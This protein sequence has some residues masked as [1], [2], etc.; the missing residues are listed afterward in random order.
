[1]N[2]PLVL[3]F[4]VG[5]QSVRAVLIDRKGTVV[6]LERE[7]YDKPYYSLHPNWAEQSPDY[8]YNQICAACRRLRDQSPT[9]FARIGWVTLTAFRDSTVCLSEKGEPLRDCILWMD[10]RTAEHPKPLPAGHRALF[11]AVGMSETIGMLQRTGACN[12]FSENEPELWE[13]TDEYVGLST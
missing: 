6:A 4:D 1:M 8:Y 7:V 5:T 9:A 2:D 10:Q 3:V 11:A 12:W 13:R